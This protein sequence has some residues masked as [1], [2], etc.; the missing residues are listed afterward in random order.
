LEFLYACDKVIYVSFAHSPTKVLLIHMY[1]YMRG[2]EVLSCHQPS[3]HLCSVKFC[4]KV[5]ADEEARRKAESQ[6]P[7]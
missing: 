7:C 3:S 6:C 5:S 1:T 4:G 2:F